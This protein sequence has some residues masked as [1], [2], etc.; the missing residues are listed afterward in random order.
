[1][2]Y[3]LSPEHM[4]ALQRF[5]TRL[6]QDPS[7]EGVESTPDKKASTLVISHV[8]MTLD[9]LFFGQWRTENFQW[10]TIAVSC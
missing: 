5:Q 4:D 10:S 9:E 6:N 1:M 7:F 3:P 2:N 8:E